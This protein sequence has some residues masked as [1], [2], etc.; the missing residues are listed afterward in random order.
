MQ[1]SYSV[2]MKEQIISSVCLLVIVV[3][4]SYL[5]AILKIESKIAWGG[6]FLILAYLGCVMTRK[7][8]KPSTALFTLLAGVLIVHIPWWISHHVNYDISFCIL[9]DYFING[10]KMSYTIMG[11]I[12]GYLL[13][14]LARLFITK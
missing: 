3:L 10:T 5:L 8:L 6:L 14:K 1:S 12:S 11:V 9:I 7:L 13:Y 4:L 2:I